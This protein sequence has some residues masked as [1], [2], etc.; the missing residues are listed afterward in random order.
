[1]GAMRS[2]R[3]SIHTQEHAF[4]RDWLIDRRNAL[5]YSQRE[6]ASELD[7][8]RS[9]IS[10]VETGDRR[11]DVIEFFEY[12]EVLGLDPCSF[13]TQYKKAFPDR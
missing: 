9:H 10:K 11:L 3:K 7:V 6:L 2:P 12:C 8:V 13:F 5:G 1:M 4:L